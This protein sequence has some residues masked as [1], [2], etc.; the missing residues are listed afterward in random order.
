MEIDIR[1]REKIR[2][3]EL[4][5]INAIWDRLT[6]RLI[7]FITRDVLER[8][9]NKEQRLAAVQFFRFSSFMT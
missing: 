2:A 1:T 3:L 6:P 4:S 7:S 9:D 8:I 5:Q